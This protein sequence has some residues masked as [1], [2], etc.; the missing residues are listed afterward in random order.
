MRLF[1][2]KVLTDIYGRAMAQ[3]VRVLYGGSVNAKN[4]ES[5]MKEGQVDGFLVGGASLHADEFATICK[6]SR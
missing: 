3:K 6:L 4:A 1:I 5:L 2:E